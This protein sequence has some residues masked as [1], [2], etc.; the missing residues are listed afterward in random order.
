MIGGYDVSGG[1][2]LT[3]TEVEG[4]CAWDRGASRWTRDVDPRVVN[5]KKSG[6]KNV[7]SLCQLFS[8]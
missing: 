2:A 4:E 1:R 5:V 3:H 6:A 7:S 8:K